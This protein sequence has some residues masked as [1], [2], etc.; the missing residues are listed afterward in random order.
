MS[1]GNKSFWK[2]TLAFVLT[3]LLVITS[4]PFSMQKV[5]AADTEFSIKLVY[6]ESGAKK[7]VEADTAQLIFTKGNEQYTYKAIKDSNNAG[8]YKFT[9]ADNSVLLTSDKISYDSL[10][11]KIDGY[12]KATIT[13]LV[14]IKKDTVA[15]FTVEPKKDGAAA[16]FAGGDKTISYSD[17]EDG[18]YDV[19]SILNVTITSEDDNALAGKTVKYNISGGNIPSSD[20]AD[21]IASQAENTN[22]ASIDSAGK[23]TGL[24]A[25]DKAYVIT[26]V[27]SFD[28]YKDA[29]ATM[30]LTVNKAEQDTVSFS[31]GDNVSVTFNNS[32]AAHEYA[33][34]V[35]RVKE[36]AIVTYAIDASS[37][38]DIATVDNTTGKVSYSKAGKVKVNATISETDNY[39]EKVISY[40]LS[41]G[42]EAVKS[43]GFQDS[44][45]EV[46][47]GDNSNKYDQRVQHAG[48]N[49]GSIAYGITDDSGNS[50]DVADINSQTGEVTIKKAGTVKITA[51]AAETDTYGSASASYTLVIKKA[52]RTVSFDNSENTIEIEYN[53]NH[54]FTNAARISD[55]TANIAYSIISGNGRVDN[56]GEVT[57]SSIGTI[58]IKA[59]VAADD[60]YNECSAEYTLTVKYAQAGSYDNYV[61]I[62]GPTKNDSGWYTGK[63][64]ISAKDGYSI[65]KSENDIWQSSLVVSTDGEYSNYNISVKNTDNGVVYNAV[66]V[67]ELKIDSKAPEYVEIKYDESLAKKALNAITFGYYK[68]EVKVTIS[69]KDD[70]SGI[71]SITYNVIENPDTDKNKKIETSPQP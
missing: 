66:S 24:T 18:A 56:T 16:I 41:I 13:N 26:A 59:Y 22:K 55:G 64:T 61:E 68:N 62:S 37:T 63:V 39:K 7:E 35:T 38:T 36:D 60:Y 31:N 27:V 28:D 54:T 43:F 49:I 71:E 40:T 34:E 11:I 8:Q 10:I 46:T 1:Y 52:D 4:T 15:E 33:N 67:P 65:R 48:G 50:T 23:I 2:R 57:Y 58:K 30:N 19:S 32:E 12:K 3:V 44:N 25:S 42:K 9:V 6:D 47:Y 29:T 5:K 45:V 20:S 70:M 17:T 53:D 14:N 21:S 69:A 51:Q